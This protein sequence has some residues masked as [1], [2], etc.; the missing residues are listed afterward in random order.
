MHKSL[1]GLMDSIDDLAKA[2]VE[3]KPDQQT[4]QQSFGWN[5]PP[6]TSSQLALLVKQHADQIRV[7]NLA[8]LSR[9]HE[10]SVEACKTSVITFQ[11]GTLPYLFNGNFAGA[12]PPYSTLVDGI[13][14]TLN[15][16]LGW[17]IVANKSSMP[18]SLARKIEN[19][20][21]SI[22]KCVVDEISLS[23]RIA[24]IN[25]AHEAA[26]ALPITLKQLTTAKT[27]VEHSS[28]SA[29][30][31]IG[32]IDALHQK[33]TEVLVAIEQN[34]KEA[35]SMAKR[36]SEAYA[37]TTSIGLGAAFDSRAT[38]LANSLKWWVGGL[39]IALSAGAVLGYYRFDRLATAMETS[40]NEPA[41]IIVELIV[42]VLSLAL[43][44][45]F[46]WIAT[47]QVQ[48]RFKLSEDYAFKASVAKAYEGYRREAVRFNPEIEERLFLAALK[49]LE[50]EPLRYVDLNTHGSPY[51]EAG[52]VSAVKDTAMEYKAIIG[53]AVKEKLGVGKSKEP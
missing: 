37:A 18:A 38:S 25:E 17:Q 5:A 7:A 28:T 41:I 19:L 20:S 44:I 47:K 39:F 35:E 9:E 3:G 40:K 36:S 10:L 53:D 4:L 6:L 49:R 12:F 16:I 24:L 8:E 29:S 23:S 11:A 2:L 26:E 15:P 52:I 13:Q 32:K 30:E 51:H 33:S 14:A 21:I 43:P 48:E 46:A 27:E 1:E 50:E 45:W 34:A 31:L 22:E 42:S